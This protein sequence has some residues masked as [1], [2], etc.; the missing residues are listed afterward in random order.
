MEANMSQLV[1]LEQEGPLATLTLNRPERHNSLVPALLEQLLGAIEELQ[2]QPDLRAVVLQANGRSFSTGGDIQAFVE[3]ADDV[4]MYSRRIVGLLNQVIL[5][6]IDLPVPVV[7]AVH[8][9]VTG[10]SLGLVLA[11][12]VVLVAPGAKFQPFY[13]AVGP[14]PD[15][16]WSV[17]LP[18]M[19]GARRAAEI[20]Y[21]NITISAQEAVAWGLA[22]RLVPAGQIRDEAQRVAKA[23]AAKKPSSIRHTKRLLYLH[24]DQV[25]A[26]L[27]AELDRFLQ[28]IVTEEA[29]DGLR[30]FLEQL[31]ADQA[32]GDGQP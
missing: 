20:L 30:A 16:G 31:H 18:A 17:L 13:S 21:L 9:V 3:K 1:L 19:V 6:M 2:Q 23:I 22:N 7:A 32:P 11:S 12:D 25:A 27:E 10:G 4:T 29:H 15:G 26:G 8:G 14:S 24:R 5:A 28:Q